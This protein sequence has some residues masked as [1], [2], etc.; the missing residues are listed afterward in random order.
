L[1]TSS[2]FHLHSSEQVAGATAAKRQSKQKKNKLDRKPSSSGELK[3]EAQMGQ[4]TQTKDGSKCNV[5]YQYQPM[6]QGT[7][8]SFPST[9]QPQGQMSPSSKTPATHDSKALQVAALTHALSCMKKYQEPIHGKL[10]NY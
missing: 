5:G 9:P 8:S 4:E 1:K 6:E 2:E 10:S 7:N 3:N